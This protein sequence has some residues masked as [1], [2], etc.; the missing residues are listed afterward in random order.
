MF[1]RKMNKSVKKIQR[2]EGFTLIEILVAIGILMIL[3]TMGTGGL[4]QVVGY[5]RQTQALQ[6]SMNDLNFVMESMSRHIRF[7]TNYEC[8]KTVAGK[9]E[10]IETDFENV[11]RI[12]YATR[13]E[14]GIGYVLQRQR[15][16]SSWEDRWVTSPE[17]VDI[18]RLNFYVEGT[19]ADDDIHPRVTIVMEGVV[20][21][22]PDREADFTLQT[23]VDQR[24][25]E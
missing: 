24:F 4:A 11:Q 25:N 10:G 9:C 20:T 14:N 7:G 12:R 19:D 15:Q 16:G 22:G 5:H 8:T 6:K 17:N 13:I 2:R 21:T 3:I 18:R 23:T 1:F